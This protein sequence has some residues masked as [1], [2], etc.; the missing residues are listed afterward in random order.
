MAAAT[1][2]RLLEAA[3]LVLKDAGIGGA[4]ARS[5]A[6]AAGLNQALV[7]YHWGGVDELLLAALDRSSAERLAAYRSAL[8]ACASLRDVLTALPGLYEQDQASGHIDVLCEMVAGGVARRGLGQEVAQRIDPWSDL[9]S[10]T[11][12][13]VVPRPLARRLPIEAASRM[14]VALFLGAEVLGR[15]HGDPQVTRHSFGSAHRLLRLLSPDTG[16]GAG[17]AR[18]SA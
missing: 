4:T 16:R 12:R 9:A 14:T 3:L 5:I 1:K 13:R 10:H 7:F 2:E 17:P 8:S 18:A 6:G 11:L 15:L